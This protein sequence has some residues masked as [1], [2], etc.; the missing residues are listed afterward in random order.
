MEKESDIIKIRYTISLFDVAAMRSHTRYVYELYPDGKVSFTHYEKG[1]R[2]PKATDEKHTATAIDFMQLSADLN[3]CIET[4]DRD[5][6]YVDDTSAEAII[7]RP[8][9]RTDTMNRGYG[10]GKTDI[11]QLISN[12]IYGVGGYRT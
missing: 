4:A 11:G 1:N 5:E 3:A 9:G 2:K 6:M 8:F 10:N 7:Y 12:Y